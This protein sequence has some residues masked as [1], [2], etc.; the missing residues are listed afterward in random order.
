MRPPGETHDHREWLGLATP[1]SRAS[2]AVDPH[3]L[4]EIEG[5]F[6]A[7]QAWHRTAR[8]HSDASRAYMQLGETDMQ[9]IRYLMAMARAGALTT[10]SML[11]RHL[12]I[13]PASVTKLLDRLEHGGH[14]LRNRHPADRRALSI[15]VT[16]STA[17][18][19]RLSVGM[20]HARRFDIA[21]DLSSDE[22][23]AATKFLR[24]LADLPIAEY[25]EVVAKN[26]PV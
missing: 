19:A 1:S 17:Q 18:A 7:L 10:P 25:P 24:K 23:I 9:A 11:G 14:V 20:D 21:A 13:S 16:P 8:E 26:A 5:L 22:R 2:E 4:Q 6:E 3:A 12:H 15:T